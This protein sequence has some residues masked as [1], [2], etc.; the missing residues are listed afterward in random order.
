MRTDGKEYLTTSLSLLTSLPKMSNMQGMKTI[1]AALLAAIATASLSDITVKVTPQG[2]DIYSI[3][4]MPSVQPEPEPVAEPERP[5]WRFAVDAI[6]RKDGLDCAAL[7]EDA[8]VE[9]IRP[10]FFGDLARVVAGEC[11]F[12]VQKNWDR[13]VSA[14]RP[15]AFIEFLG[16]RYCP[17]GADNDPNGLNQHW[18]GN[19]SKFVVEFTPR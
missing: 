1:S 9:N 8:I 13:W 11:A 3:S 4:V 7:F 14:G 5:D 6:A 10:D 2:G 17:V 16:A 19:V 15:G 18:V 12:T